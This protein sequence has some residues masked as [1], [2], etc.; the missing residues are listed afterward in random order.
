MVIDASS[1]AQGLRE[2]LQLEGVQ[3][4]DSVDWVHDR[5]LECLPC[6][7]ALHQVTGRPYGSVVLALERASRP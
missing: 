6:E 1:C 7:L 2:N 4:L 5:L 3:V